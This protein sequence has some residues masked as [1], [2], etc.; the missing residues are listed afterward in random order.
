MQY[1]DHSR[2]FDRIDQHR[3][4]FP[5]MRRVLL[6]RD[7]SA[8]RRFGPGGSANTMVVAAL[9]VIASIPAAARAKDAE[10]GERG[11]GVNVVVHG[12]G[13][14]RA[15]AI[16]RH[17]EVLRS[18]VFTRLLD[19]PSPA[20]WTVRCIVHVHASTDSF[21]DAVGG[22][23]AAARGATSLQFAGERVVSRRIDVM[24][25]GPDIVPDSLAHELVHVVLA[26]HFV[27]AA[28]PRWADEGLALLFDAPE[29][30]REHEADFRDAMRRGLA[31][32]AAD[33]LALEDYPAD[34]RRQ[35][36]FYGQSAALVRWLIA[37]RNAATFIHFVDDSRA[38]G[39]G[40]ALERHYELD[41]SQAVQLAWKETAPIHTLGLVDRVR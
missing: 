31:W 27:R 24:G 11:R 1:V 21:I 3:E 7:S 36:V 2:S 34:S 17:A 18:Q 19:E 23:P 32:P 35:R 6:I 14:Q 22:A 30:Q 4:P 16:T 29:K 13:P 33:L 40:P 5:T 20:D 15:A 37:R 26:D 12:T 9:L 28:P 8:G 41:S 38:I 39:F 10:A 25:D